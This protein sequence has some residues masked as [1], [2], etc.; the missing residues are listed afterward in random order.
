[1]GV[2]M[3]YIIFSEVFEHAFDDSIKIL[4]F[5]FLTYLTIEYIQHKTKSR[6]AASLQKLKKYGP[7]LG[8]VLGVIPQCGFSSMAASFYTGRIITMGTL[9]SVYLATSDEMLPVMISSG[10]DHKLIAKILILKVIVGLLSGLLIDLIMSSKVIKTNRNHIRIMPITAESNNDFVF[11]VSK[12][13]GQCYCC[14]R[15]GIL[16]AAVRHCV[17]TFLFLFI[18]TVILTF[19]FH[20][21]GEDKLASFILNRPFIGEGLAALIGL[22]PNCAASV[23]LTELYLEGAMAFSSMM[24]GLFAGSGV[25]I[26]VLFRENR[27]RWSENLKILGLLYMIAVAAG[28][29]IRMID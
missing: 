25:G 26:L 27:Q 7:L 16:F 17:S 3:K 24:S 5:L 19:V 9:L 23:I 8:S 20:E 15:G 13:H 21:F 10:A 2:S 4:P 29:Y 28:W 11:S 18:I 22:I 1:M 12:R 14:K 6:N